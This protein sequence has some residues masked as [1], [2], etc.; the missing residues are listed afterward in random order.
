VQSGIIFPR[1]FMLPDAEDFPAALPER[2]VHQTVTRHVS[3]KLPLP[4]RPPGGGLGA[5]L[6]AAVPK[7]AVHKYRQL[8]FGKDEVRSAEDFPPPPAGNA[9]LAE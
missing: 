3:L 2:A 4:K 7:T 1:K 5:V 8:G 9:V 6:R